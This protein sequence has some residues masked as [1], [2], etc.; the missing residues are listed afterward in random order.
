M[1]A[2]DW[3]EVARAIKEGRIAG[4][5]ATPLLPKELFNATPA[6]LAAREGEAARTTPVHSDGCSAIGLDA[7]GRLMEERRLGDARVT[8]NLADRQAMSLEPLPD[9]SAEQRRTIDSKRGVGID[10][11]DTAYVNTRRMPRL[12]ASLPDL[13]KTLGMEDDI[14]RVV[15]YLW[16]GALRGGFHYDEEANV[17]VQLVGEADVW[18]IPQNYTIPATGGSRIMNPPSQRVLET[19]PF[20]K[21]VPFHVFRIGPGQGVTFPAS[22]YHLFCAQ[23]PERV[24]I[25]F[26]FIPKWRRM[27]YHAADWYHQEARRPVGGLQRLALRQLWARSF[28]RLWDER[29][30]SLIWNAG[31]NE[32]L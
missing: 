29:G 3:K 8:F 11:C 2:S 4:F 19:D 28:A 25:N 18:L 27:E 23:S 26:F 10:Y 17:Y 21:Q 32:L 5:D 15:S 6:V 20:W 24:A 13:P 1:I 31:K 12:H 16:M 30:R 14:L 7:W 22:T 9:V